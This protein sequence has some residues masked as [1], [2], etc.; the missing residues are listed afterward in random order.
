[1]SS[2]DDESDFD[3]DDAHAYPVHDAAEAGD[4]EQLAKLLGITADGPPPGDSEEN[5]AHPWRCG[6][7]LNERDDL[8]G[9]T[10]LHVA[11]MHGHVECA[12]LLVGAGADIGRKLC[13][14][15]ATHLAVGLG[16][17][18]D[19]RDRCVPLLMLFVEKDDLNLKAR[20]ASPI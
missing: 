1:M 20:T 9:R 6:V 15:S 3:D 18:R 4:V 13:G 14:A 19:L 12:R 11:L 8:D 5:G 17:F 7:D 16:A 10:P 2:D